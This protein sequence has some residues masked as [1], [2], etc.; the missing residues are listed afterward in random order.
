LLPQRWSGPE[1]AP[2]VIARSWFLDDTRD[3]N[4]ELIPV[5]LEH[6]CWSVADAS[7]GLMELLPPG[8]H[9]PVQDPEAGQ[10]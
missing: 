7:T 5:A 4:G 6:K 8:S 3:E 2:A 10:V 9:F 1:P